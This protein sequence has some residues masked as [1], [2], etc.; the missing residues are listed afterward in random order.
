MVL[1][2]IASRRTDDPKVGVGSVIIHADR[3]VSVGWNGFPRK[4]QNWDYP[5]GGADDEGF[6]LAIFY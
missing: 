5:H 2:H 1:A 3:Y 6:Q 4:A